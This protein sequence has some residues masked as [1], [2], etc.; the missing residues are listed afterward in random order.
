MAFSNNILPTEA[1]Y[2]T[3]NNATIKSTTLSI[4][5]GGS[6]FYKIDETVL[7]ALPKS[8]SFNYRLIS[9]L[10][11]EPNIKVQFTFVLSNGTR[12]SFTIFPTSLTGNIYMITIDTKDGEYTSCTI[13]L[14]SDVNCSMSLWELCPEASDSDI[15]TVIDNVK[16][17]LPRVLYDYNTWPFTVEQVEST[18]ALITCRLK[19]D[20]DIQGHFLMN[21]TASEQAIV[22]LRFYDNEGEELFAPLTYDIHAGYNTIGVPHAFLTRLTGLHTFAVTAQTTAGTLSMDTRGVLFTIDGGYLASREIT[23]GLNVRDLAIK[24][25]SADTTPEEIWL[26]GIDENEVLVRKR[27]YSDQNANV[28]FDPVASIGEGIDAAIEFDGNWV[29]RAGTDQFT[30]ET[31]VEPWVFWVDTDNNLY[32]KHGVTSNEVPILLDT[33]VTQVRACKG[34]SSTVY[35][36]Q[37]QGLTIAYLKNGKPYY[38]QYVYSTVSQT[39]KWLDAVLLIDEEITTVQI[40]RLNDYRLSFELSN[41]EHNLWLYTSRTY[42]AQTVPVETINLQNNENEFCFLYCPADIDQTV[43]IKCSS[44]DD[45][46]EYY[47][48]FNRE[49]VGEQYNLSDCITI[50]ET[51][52]ELFNIKSM[53]Y[54]NFTGSARITIKLKERSKTLITN[55][56]VCQTVSNKL[57]CKIED[58]GTIQCPAYVGTIDTTVYRYYDLPTE[59]FSLSSSGIPIYTPITSK[60]QGVSE[61]FTTTVDGNPVYTEVSYKSQDVAE[62]FTVTQSGVP[63]YTQTG[64][65]PI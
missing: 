21:F 52:V 59:Q 50:P 44:S 15:E 3:L 20:T 48:D 34:Y 1:A 45:G 17:S 8:F 60:T 43:T 37:D 28:S 42:V 63:V 56:Y 64:S 55:V 30:I 41:S 35:L 12:Q 22:T 18:V 29:L 10:D 58:Y 7:A 14:T 57:L 40:H 13:K 25:T 46:L 49:L 36:D 54:E 16:Q 47:L 26:V 19:G 27:S 6:A 32:G 9:P 11:I 38:K 5:A 61:Q 33:E 2:Y 65:Q 51:S 4:G 39:K 24:Q 62:T 23:I 53:S 31:E